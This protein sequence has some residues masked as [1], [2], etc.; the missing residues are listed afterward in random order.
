MTPSV[1]PSAAPSDKSNAAS[2]VPDADAKDDTKLTTGAPAP[3]FR[4]QRVGVEKIASLQA[5]AGRPLVIIFGS[6]TSPTFRDKAAAFEALFRKHKSRVGFLVIYT[7]EAYPV[8]EWEP[9][10]NI[11]EQIKIAAHTTLN[12]RTAMAKLTR[13]GLKITLDMAVDDID[14][15]VATAYRATPN[16]LVLIDSGGK[17]AYVQRWA[18]PFA[19]DAAIADLAKTK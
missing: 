7:R 2:S 11:D 4:L 5:Y 1:T 16:G 14:D 15:A 13:D 10:R 19:L 18:D 8:N 6:F 12:E 17:I 3:A 9:Q